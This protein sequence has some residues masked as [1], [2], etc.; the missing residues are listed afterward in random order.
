MQLYTNRLL[1]KFHMRQSS[2]VTPYLVIS[3]DLRGHLVNVH[4]TD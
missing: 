3:V 1:F 4:E 2:S